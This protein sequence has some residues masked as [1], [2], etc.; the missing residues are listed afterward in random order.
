MQLSRPQG[1]C[2][3]MWCGVVSG[4]HAKHAKGI[5]KYDPYLERLSFQKIVCIPP[6]FR[7]F[8]TWNRKKANLTP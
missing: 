2:G 4:Q 1:W 8:F 6:T 3:V 5:Q 7:I